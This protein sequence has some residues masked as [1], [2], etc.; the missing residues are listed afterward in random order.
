MPCGMF[1]ATLAISAMSWMVLSLIGRAFDEELAAVVVD[2]FDG[3][4][5]QVRGEELRLVLDLARRDGERGAADRRRPAAVRAPAHRRVVG[6][7]VNHLHVVDVDA[8]LVGDDLREGRLL[9][10]AVRRRADEHVHLAARMEA[11]DGAFPQAALESRS[12]PATC[13][14]PRPQ[15]ST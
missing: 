8:E 12:A 15:I 7:A 11:D 4:F 5:E 14:G 13:D 2:V 9:A 6:V 3:G 1:H 10:L